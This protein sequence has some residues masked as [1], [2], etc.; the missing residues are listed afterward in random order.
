VYASPLPKDSAG[1]EWT[2]TRSFGRFFILH[3]RISEWS[4]LYSREL[5]SGNKGG[6]ETDYPEKQHNTTHTLLE[7]NN[8][9]KLDDEPFLLKQLHRLSDFPS[10]LQLS[11]IARAKPHHSGHAEYVFQG[12]PSQ[13]KVMRVNRIA[14]AARGC[15]TLHYRRRYVSLR[16][17]EVSSADFSSSF[18]FQRVVNIFFWS[19]STCRVLR[20]SISVELERGLNKKRDWKRYSIDVTSR[21]Q[22][23]GIVN[24]YQSCL[25]VSNSPCWFGY[26][27][28]TML[29]WIYNHLSVF[30]SNFEHTYP[31]LL[32]Y[33][34]AVPNTHTLLRKRDF[35]ARQISLTNFIC[36]R[37][38]KSFK[39]TVEIH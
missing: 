18:P 31:L 15:I 20:A 30:P 32:Q 25:F 10:T 3:A 14:R 7:L 21:F 33:F 8:K 17:G 16:I 5:G 6:S 11:I 4:S 9:G 26:V 13:I 19:R 24:L 2:P 12:T 22:R 37:L 28:F 1:S 29:N 27:D 36:H 34:Q 35:K 39:P 23:K 38:P